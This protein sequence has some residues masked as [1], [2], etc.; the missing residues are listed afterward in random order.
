MHIKGACDGDTARLVKGRRLDWMPAHTSAANAASL[1][2]ASGKKVSIIDWRANNLADHLARQAAE[3][4]A[5]PKRT[6]Q[7]VKHATDMVK[8]A[9]AKLG[10]VTWAANNHTTAVT[11]PDGTT[12]NVVKRDA[13]DP[14][15]Y[16]KGTSCTRKRARPQP[17][18]PADLPMFAAKYRTSNCRHS[19]AISRAASRKAATVRELHRQQLALRE[20][21][22]RTTGG[23]PDQKWDASKKPCQR[24][25][26]SGGSRAHGP[27]SSISCS[28]VLL[29]AV[30]VTAAQPPVCDSLDAQQ[31]T[32]ASVADCSSNGPQACPSDERSSSSSAPQPSTAQNSTLQRHEFFCR[33]QHDGPGAETTM[34]A[35]GDRLDDLLELARLDADG[36]AVCWPR[37]LPLRQLLALRAR[38]M[39]T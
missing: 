18:E 5:P 8:C 27:N 21:I 30:L 6:M 28:P 35:R 7:L 32:Q 2:K 17:A 9:A 22:S 11:Q 38:V 31:A 4:N 39:A 25:R 15:R 24:R 26:T 23:N 37:H 3:A 13:C 29:P 12:K 14:P 34:P 20:I 33:E 1:K 16:K 19:A 36:V 10:L